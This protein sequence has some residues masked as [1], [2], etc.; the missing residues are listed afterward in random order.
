MYQAI[1]DQSLTTN[2]YRNHTPPKTTRH[3]TFGDGEV[4]QLIDECLA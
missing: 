4:Q 1:V 2:V 3:E